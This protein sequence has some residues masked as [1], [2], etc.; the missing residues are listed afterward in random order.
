MAERYV[1]G[2]VLGG[3]EALLARKGTKDKRVSANREKTY[4]PVYLPT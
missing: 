3:A 4:L 2:K 1:A